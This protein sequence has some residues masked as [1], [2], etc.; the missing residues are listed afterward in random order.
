MADCGGTRADKEGWERELLDFLLHH[1]NHSVPADLARAVADFMIEH[2]DFAPYD[3]IEASKQDHHAV[4]ALQHVVRWLKENDA[5]TLLAS[6]LL[7]WAVDI[8]DGT[9]EI[10]KRKRGRPPKGYPLFRDHMIATVVGE[11]AAIGLR[12]ATS[13]KMGDPSASACHMVAAVLHQDSKSIRNIYN[14]HQREEREQ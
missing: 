6:P 4:E 13:N 11:I 12:R 14:R 1:V 7:D 9:R 5:I 8:A 10:P 3:L 2:G